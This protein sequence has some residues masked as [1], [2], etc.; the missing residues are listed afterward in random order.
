M[1]M[2]LTQFI[3]L[4]EPQFLNKIWH[5]SETIVEPIYTKLSN[6]KDMN[7]QLFVEDFKMA[8]FGPLQT[9]SEGGPVTYDEA[10]TPIRRRYDYTVRGLGYQITDKLVRNE[11]FGQVQLFERDLKRAVDDDIETFVAALYNNATNTTISAGFDGLSLANTA[12]LRQDGGAT[13]ANRPTTLSALDL[14]GLQAGL[15]QF[16]KWVNDRGRPIRSKPLRLVIPPD[17][18]LTARELLESQM[19]PDTANNATNV[20]TRYGLDIVVWRYLTSTT[21]WSLVGDMHDINF[22]SQFKPESKSEVDFDTDV[23]K[24]KS[25]WAGA[26]GHGHFIGFYLGN[27]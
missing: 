27:T 17:L 13:Q 8:G 25:R 4:A 22:Y 10:L 18:E 15:I 26:R 3:A 9:I 11:Q 24:R 23:I 19:R 6:Q 14:G 2:T 12:H 16:N 20:I 5:E 7:D 1:P 21:F